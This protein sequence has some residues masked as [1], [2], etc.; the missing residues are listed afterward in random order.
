MRFLPATLLFS[1]FWIAAS[2]PVFATSVVCIRSPDTIAI[3][4]DSVLAAKWGSSP[5]KAHRE[6][7]IIDAGGMFF[8]MTGFVKDPAR[9]YD[10]AR[11]VRFSLD[12]LTP[13]R[14][15]ATVVTKEVIKDLAEELRKL[16]LEVPQLYQKLTGQKGA[17]L[18]VL[19]AVFDGGMPRVVQLGFNQAVSSMGEITVTVEQESCPG[20]CDPG[21]INMFVLGDRRPIDAYLESGKADWKSP[22]KAAKT[23]VEK[24]IAAG[25]PDVGPPVDVLRI[26]GDGARWIERK[27]ECPEITDEKIMLHT[28]LTDNTDKGESKPF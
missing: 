15:P 8:S 25:T 26:D 11:I 13:P 28:D 21:R 2:P 1:F 16:K 23:M 5:G 3:A 19:L 24:V 9:N 27:E 6:C 10:A 14:D 4:A 20:E 12:R 22:E 18:K 7:K 17:L